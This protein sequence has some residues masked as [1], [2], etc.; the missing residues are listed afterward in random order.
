V[1]TIN[2]RGSGAQTGPVPASIRRIKVC[3][4]TP[5][6][7]H[8]LIR[9]PRNLDFAHLGGILPKSATQHAVI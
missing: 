2:I 5:I 4:P 6:L 1:L 3:G 8:T 9:A 7:G